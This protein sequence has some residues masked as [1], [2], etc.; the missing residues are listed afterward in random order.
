MMGFFVIMFAMNAQPKGGNAGGGGE[1][2]EGVAPQPDMIDFAIAVRKAFHNEVD[3]SSDDPQDQL[4]IQRIL[5]SQHG[6]AGESKDEGTRGKDQNVQSVR[7]S[8]HF[9]RGTSVLFPPRS[10]AISEAAGRSLA[11]LAKQ[12]RGQATVVEVRGHVGAS[13]N[14]G[15]PAEAMT[16]AA[17]RALAAANRLAAGGIDWWRIRVVAAGSGERVEPFP[18]D[19][20]ADAKNARVEVRVLDEIAAPREP[21]KA[22]E[23]ED[24]R[25]PGI[26]IDLDAPKDGKD[27]KDSK[28]AGGAA[29]P[30]AATVGSASGSRDAPAGGRTRAP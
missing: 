23:G 4:L 18:E 29:A 11:E 25:K 2:S 8:D 26:R 28:D 3:M 6:G 17:D 27:S 5:Q 10:A 7:Q 15:E 13:E 14:Y 30:A 12:L 1:Q 9:G 16:L 19:A 24:A 20:A 22:G 21:G